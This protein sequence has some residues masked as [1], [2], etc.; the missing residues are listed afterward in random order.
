M[1]Y[2]VFV[3]IETDDGLVGWGDASDWEASHATVKDGYMI[4]NDR[5]GFGTDLIES[6]LNKHYV[7]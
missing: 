5:P 1:R 7:E 2:W 4:V 6:E 3:K